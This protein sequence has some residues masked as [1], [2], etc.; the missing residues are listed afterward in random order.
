MGSREGSPHIS[1]EPPHTADRAV[2]LEVL[3][4]FEASVEGR[5]PKGRKEQP[6]VDI[7]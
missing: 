3:A 4:L 2:M 5:V 7:E 6:V 1:S